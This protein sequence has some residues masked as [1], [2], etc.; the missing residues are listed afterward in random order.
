M[1]DKT[2]HSL[3]SKSPAHHRGFYITKSGLGN[4]PL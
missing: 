3:E 4:Q 2:P 1:E